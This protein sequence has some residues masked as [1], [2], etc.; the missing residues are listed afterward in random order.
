MV[1][2][3]NQDMYRAATIRSPN[4]CTGE[5]LGI[6]PGAGKKMEWVFLKLSLIYQLTLLIFRIP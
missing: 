1:Y 3:L 6:V 4:P 5:L 2:E